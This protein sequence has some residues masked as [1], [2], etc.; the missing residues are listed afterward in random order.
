MRKLS[1]GFYEI[2]I[3]ILLLLCLLIPQLTGTAEIPDPSRS[4]DESGC[5]I[6]HLTLEDLK[7][8]GTRVGILTGNDW[9]LELMRIFPDG[10]F[11][12]YNSL[13]DTYAAISSGQ[14]DTALSFWDLRNNLAKSNPDLAFITEPVA[15]IGI[16]FAT[17]KNEKGDAL[18]KDFNTYIENLNKTGQ[19]QKLRDKWEDPDLKG[20]VM[21]TYEFSGENGILRVAAD[22]GWVPMGFYEGNTLT[23][24]FIELVNGFCAE[25]GYTPKFETV[26]EG[27]ALAGL[28]SGTYDLIAHGVL[29]TEERRKSV[30]ITDVLMI[31]EAY[32]VVKSDVVYQEVPG[33]TAFFSNIKY[34]FRRNFIEEDRYKSLLSGLKVTLLLTV[35]VTIFGTVLSGIICFLRMRKNKIAE[36]FARLYLRIFRGIP[37]VTLLLLLY[38]VVFA[39]TVLDAFWVSVIGFSI[40]FSVYTS[41]MFRSGICAVP[42]GQSR[43]AKAMG[44][45][46]IQ[47]FRK[48]IWPQ[49]WTNILPVYTGEIAA[50]L[51][52]TSIAGYISVMDLTKAS[53]L[54]RARTFE[55]FFPMVFTALV[56]FLLTTIITEIFRAVEKRASSRGRKVKKEILETVK[57]FD[58]LEHPKYSYKKDSA[59]QRAMDAGRS[60]S[61][62]E[63]TCVSEPVLKVEHL[64]KS[65]GSTVPLKDINFSV[66]SGDVIAIIGPSGTG[67]STLLNMINRLEKPDSGNIFFEGQDTMIKGYDLNAMRQNI[68]MVFQSFNLFSN[69]TIIE[70]LM[71][72]QT[73]ILKRSTKEACERG[74]ELLHQVGLA[75]CALHTPDQLSGGQQQRA[76]I[77]RTV[78]MDPHIIL[79]DEPTSALDPAMIDEVL[80]VMRN[81]A[82]NGM[83]MLV[84]TH[85][86]RFAMNVSNRVF[87]IDEGV[88]LEEG[89]PVQIF[90]AP[91]NEKVRQFLDH[92]QIFTGRL[93]KDDHSFIDEI[94]AFEEF[95][96]S[97]LFGRN[98]VYKVLYLLEELCQNTILPTLKEGGIDLQFEYS[99]DEGMY[100][101]AT[102]KGED[103]ETS[104]SLRGAVHL[105]CRGEYLPQNG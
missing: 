75:H 54:I 105:R 58:P 14:I 61:A 53:D 5:P 74:M 32:M 42:E 30:N 19:M 7:K 88:I 99:A 18:C 27:P 76:A 22:G 49:A 43:A 62:A 29:D 16:G 9:G 41:E 69:L 67:K 10:Q 87:F 79:F 34:S 59:V 83:T 60:V 64:K 52:M 84:V 25:Y 81:L 37:V 80:M 98:L 44:F 103:A 50:T 100:M 66:S 23:G 36:A 8:P 31:D 95:A 17:Q 55:A 91:Q 35:L 12:Q 24:M 45:S 26:D 11:F 72:A 104:A 47:T 92:R 85:E 48:I 96:F 1:T 77:M 70:N 4:L 65:F 3:F 86:M 78:A 73:D 20:D 71:L 57:A 39:K 93:T 21:G 68:G 90:D 33:S 94:S 6:T 13:P 46:S 51:K 2:M 56:Y 63:G 15:R 101:T 89:T 102:Y 38:Y 40:D 28:I 97:H 82:N